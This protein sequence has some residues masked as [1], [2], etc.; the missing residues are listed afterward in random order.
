MSLC[1]NVIIWANTFKYLGVNFVASRKLTID[2]IP[3]KRKF[4]V[5]CNCILGRAKCL[6]DIIELSLIESY[7]LPILTY[8]TVAMKLSQVQISDLNAC[9]N[10]VYPRIFGFY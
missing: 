1:Y 6:D 5:A 2:A 8:Y 7:C 3:I 10:S 4:C 9:W